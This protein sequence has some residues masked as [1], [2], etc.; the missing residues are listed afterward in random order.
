MGFSVPS[1]AWG[2]NLV[3]T[4]HAACVAPKLSDP[5]V[6]QKSTQVSVYS[7]EGGGWNKKHLST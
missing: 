2:L 4:L 6:L 1:S 7:D 3:Y 5:L